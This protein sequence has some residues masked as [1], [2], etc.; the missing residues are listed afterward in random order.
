M[1]LSISSVKKTFQKL[2]GPAQFYL[3]LSLLSLVIY[4]VHMLEHR[5]KLNT[6]TGL[7]MQAI[8]V[9]V[10]TAILNW[11]CSLKYGNKVAWFL[12][13]LPVILLFTMLIVFYHMVDTMGI[14]KQELQTMVSE[15]NEDSCE[16]CS[17]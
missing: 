15:L 17:H 9:I 1:K 12:V 3:V 7:T 16:E 4:L 8:I 11:V 2:C 14:T 6:A 10:W 13:F 5:N